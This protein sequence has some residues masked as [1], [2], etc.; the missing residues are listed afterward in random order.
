MSLGIKMY[1][2][3]KP[4]PNG[5]IDER[6]VSSFACKQCALDHHRRY[7]NDP[8]FLK[9]EGE[10]KA[11]YRSA[12]ENKEKARQ[13]ERKRRLENPEVKEMSRLS[14]RKNREKRNAFSRLYYQ[15]NKPF[16]IEKMKEYRNENKELFLNHVR[17][18]RARIAGA[19]GSHTANDIKNILK[20][21]R[22]RCASCKIDVSSGY[23]IDHIFPIS[24]GGSNS[25]DNLQ[26]LCEPCNKAKHAKD[27]FKW[28]NMNGRLL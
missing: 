19:E 9:R 24:R 4:C 25:P 17:K 22:N 5:H 20:L 23:H 2:T 11:L 8:Q 1:F 18:R 15:K 6:Y 27:P 10:Y 28:A 16:L 21:Q 26:I 12:E 14:A 3:G 13:Y 7:R